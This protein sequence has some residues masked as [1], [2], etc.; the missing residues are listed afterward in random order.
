M[1]NDTF[2]MAKHGPNYRD[3]PRIDFGPQ[4]ERI[5]ARAISFEQAC[6]EQRERDQEQ[7]TPAG[8]MS[9]FEAA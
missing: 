9:L 6:R 7:P 2:T 8:Q 3:A 1:A 4:V 5:I